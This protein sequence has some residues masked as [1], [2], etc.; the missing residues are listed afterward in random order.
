[1]DPE[2]TT[3]PPN[4]PDKPTANS[5]LGSAASVAG[6]GLQFALSILLFVWVGQWVDGKLGTTPLFLVLGAF[7]GAAAGFT[8]IYRK[9]TA[10]LK[11]HEQ[12]RRE[13]KERG[14]R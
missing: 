13:R 12:Q 2:R 5:S 7:I 8:S 11:R 9:L 14:S 3:P 4:G 10:D 1:M 6:M